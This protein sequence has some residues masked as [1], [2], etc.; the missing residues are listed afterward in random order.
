MR[1]RAAFGYTPPR[2]ASLAYDAT[3]MASVLAQN[4]T[5]T[6]FSASAL[7]DANGFRGVDGIFRLRP[8][9]SV[10]RA[11]AIHEV[12]ADGFRVIQPAA[13]SFQPPIN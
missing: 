12:T 9:G 13:D 11:Y 3:A 2:L 10:E 6:D 5:A 7:T 4:P 8:D 1:F